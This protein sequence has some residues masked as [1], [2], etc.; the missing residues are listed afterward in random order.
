MTPGALPAPP[1]YRPAVEQWVAKHLD[2]LFTGP[3]AGSR[4][5]R[6]G[7]LAARAAL[8]AYDVSGYAQQ[9]NE[10]WPPSRRGASQLSPYIRHG[11]LQLPEVWDAVAGG[12]QRDV[13]KF[14]EEL[15]WQE[16][17]RHLYARVGR[18]TAQPLRFRQTRPPDPD[19]SWTDGMACIAGNLRELD[20]DG[21][22][23]NQTRM[24]LAAD[25][26]NRSNGDWR[27]GEDRFFT[28][29]L[30][31]SRAANRLGWQWTA[32]LLTGRPYG[33]VRAQVERRAPGMCAACPLSND[34][35]IETHPDSADL[36]AVEPDPLLRA[37]PDATHTAGPQQALIDGKPDVVWLTA[38]SLGDNDPALLAQPGMPAVFV[39]DDRLLVHLQLSAKRL[40]FLAEC[41]GD[42]ATRRDVLVY[43]GAPRQVLAGR[44]AAATFTPVPG[45]R[46][47]AERLHLAE[48][49]PWPWLRPPHA[50]PVSS[51]S[52]WRRHIDT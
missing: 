4:H 29:L 16:Y 43:R 8:G 33:F 13:H 50:G 11:L 7:R 2:G 20:E 49:H 23:V 41:L 17:A 10:V 26:V 45:W 47:L 42:L 37:D 35:P 31:G 15:L 28:D 14:R 51:F 9:R 25:W 48:V 22:L 21:W 46:R 12:P 32:G 52:A 40:V 24:W 18:A 39:F 27:R 38:E 3:A 44:A 19:V 36:V 34:C 6:G 1:N 30:D 5:F